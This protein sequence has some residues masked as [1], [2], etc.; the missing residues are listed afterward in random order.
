MRIL[1]IGLGSMGK[2]R[3]RNLTAL[4]ETDIVAFDLREDRRAFA[5]SEYGIRTVGEI[6]EELFDE[7]EVYV[8]ST[9]PDHHAPYIRHAV[10]R[11]RP[12]FVEAS[13][14]SA[15]LDELDRAA[16]AASVTICPSCTLRFHPSVRAI[17][18]VVTSG[19]HGKVTSFDYYMGQYLPDW[20][21]WE[22]IRTFYVGKR[23]T[24]ASREM[25]PFEL[26]WLVDV[27]GWPREVVGLL[28]STLD[29]GV[30]IDD[31]Y[32]VAMRGD[33]WIGSLTVDV[34]ARYALRRLVLNLEGAQ[35]Q[36]SWDDKFVRLYDAETQEWSEIREPEGE[37]AAA[38]G[39]NP[40]IIEQMY[41]DE[42]AAFLSAARGDV[43]FPS[44]L[45]DD[46]AVLRIL[47]AVEATN[48]GASLS[49][50]G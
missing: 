40:N 45:A 28:G 38:A 20:H 25:V 8:I 21:P 22:D 24:S 44:T 14:L 32:A 19:R 35:L 31:T 3:L 16:R 23:E 7:R 49:Y 4:G 11:G 1:Q 18:D 36:W 26:T 17:K 42:M 15:G 34:V 46:I 39:Y 10:E 12:A 37:A 2:R 43:P 29:M 33:G 50:E 48:S 9:P 6:S 27:V 13:V 5:E 30:D 41:I 47:E